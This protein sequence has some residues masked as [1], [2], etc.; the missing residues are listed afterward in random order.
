M[1]RERAKKKDMITIKVPL[2][3]ILAQYPETTAEKMEGE[4][5]QASKLVKGGVPSEVLF[6]ILDQNRILI[7]HKNNLSP[8]S[9]GTAKTQEFRIARREVAKETIKSV[10]TPDGDQSQK[11]IYGR[12]E[13]KAKSL[14]EM[15]YTYAWFRVL[16]GELR[17]K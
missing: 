14:G 17:A 10:L 7:P 9:Q 4:L 6:K 2:A 5:K 3:D 16:Y 13:E 8:Q 15:P 12:Y 11:V 1:A